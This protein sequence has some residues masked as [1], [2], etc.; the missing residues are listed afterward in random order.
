VDDLYIYK[1]K[2]DIYGDAEIIVEGEKN[3]LLAKEIDAIEPDVTT[4]V[5]VAKVKREKRQKRAIAQQIEKDQ[6]KIH[7]CEICANQY[8]YRHALEVHMRR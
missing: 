6:E 7:I 1:Y 5:K 3:E 2:T 8:K 4:S